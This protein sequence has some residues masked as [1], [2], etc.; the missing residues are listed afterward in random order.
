M[1]NPPTFGLVD[2]FYR[3]DESEQWQ[4]I[5]NVLTFRP[6][7]Y[8]GSVATL[9]FG[10]SRDDAVKFDQCFHPGSHFEWKYQFANDYLD[11]ENPPRYFVG[12]I[13]SFECNTIDRTKNE[14][15]TYTLK[16]T[17]L[18]RREHE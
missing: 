14:E 4:S 10:H 8:N 2:V 11:Q 9:T 17:C 5:Y 7:T 15:I 6:P 16:V 1:I 3:T 13:Q 18:G 12:P